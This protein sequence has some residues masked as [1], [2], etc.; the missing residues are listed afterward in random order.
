[1]GMLK[2]P[3][4]N[5]TPVRPMLAPNEQFDES[6][7]LP[8]QYDLY[9]A[10][11]KMDGIRCLIAN[12]ALYS[13][14][15]KLIPNRKLQEKY[16]PFAMLLKNRGIILDGEL[17]TSELE[18]NEIQSEVMSYQKE[19]TPSLTF[20]CFDY[21]Y[22][23][24]NFISFLGRLENLVAFHTSITVTNPEFLP[25]I[26]LVEQHKLESLED[27]RAYHKDNLDRGE[28]GTIIKHG[29]YGYC[30][31]RCTVKEA[32]IFKLKKWHTLD[33][34]IHGFIQGTIADIDADK[35]EDEFGYSKTSR[36]KDD[37]IPAPILAA[38]LTKY[39]GVELRVSV[40]TLTHDE[41]KTLWEIRDT[42]LGK[43]IEYKGILHGAKSVP[44]SPKFFRFRKDKDLENLI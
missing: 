30:H 14:S 18:F 15:G 8:D 21:L 24:A 29:Y 9:V 36:K 3:P 44:R 27:L 17:W 10:S 20:H 7:I 31:K 28:E 13:R 32:T 40:N 23:S 5:V 42:L 4:R 22:K 34:Q 33:G 19:L 39:R 2:L 6:F 43:Y 38:F 12:G 26:K 41:R 37:R 11:V 1:M 35:D 16:A 25:L